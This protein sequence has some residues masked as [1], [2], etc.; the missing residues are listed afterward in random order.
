VIADIRMIN[1]HLF[2][3]MCG[4]KRDEGREGDKEKK[5]QDFHKLN[6]AHFQEHS[7]RVE[8][9]LKKSFREMT[10]TK[11]VLSPVSFRFFKPRYKDED[12]LRF[13]N[14]NYGVK[15]VLTDLEKEALLHIEIYKISRGGRWSSLAL[16]KLEVK[17]SLRIDKF[18]QRLVPTIRVRGGL[19]GNNGEIRKDNI[20]GGDNSDVRRD[21]QYLQ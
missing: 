11:L 18:P 13:E 6:I 8:E 4:L 15:F 12:F 21:L 3:F 19:A 14:E 7:K 17:V 20:G 16:R 2:N 5:M 10:R 1:L 9:Y